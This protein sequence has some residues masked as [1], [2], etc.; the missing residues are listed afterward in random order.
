MAVSLSEGGSEEGTVHVYDSATGNGNN[1]SFHII[2]FVMVILDGYKATG[3]AASRSLTLTFV[4]G[5]VQGTC[6]SHGPD[7]G[8]RVVFICAVD[9]IFDASDCTDQ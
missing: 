7:T 3:A 1:A 5:V 8:V 4:Q 9:P 2:G 6:C